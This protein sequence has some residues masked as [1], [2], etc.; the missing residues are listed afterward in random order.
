MTVRCEKVEPRHEAARGLLHDDEDLATL[1]P[2]FG[3]PTRPRQAHSRP[4]IRTNDCRVEIRIPID[5]RRAEKSHCHAP[6]LQPVAKH[7]WHGTRR[8]RHFAQL[9]IAYRKG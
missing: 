4:L 1:S 3:R 6:A 2:R 5:L 8:E 7:F 9:S